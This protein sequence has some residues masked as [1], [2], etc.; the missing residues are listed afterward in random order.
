MSQDWWR[1]GDTSVA[2]AI[3]RKLQN[4]DRSVAAARKSACATKASR[5]RGKGPE[6]PSFSSRNF[7]G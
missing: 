3:C 7:A 2:D 6:I 5:P 4:G 1:R